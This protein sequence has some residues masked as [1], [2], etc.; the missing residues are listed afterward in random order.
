[1]LSD[2]FTPDPAIAAWLTA[3]AKRKL[4]TG[5]GYSVD[6]TPILPGRYVFDQEHLGGERTPKGVEAPE[7]F[8]APGRDRRALFWRPR[9]ALS[10]RVR[11]SVCVVRV[12]AQHAQAVR[13][14]GREPVARLG[15]GR[16]FGRARAGAER[17]D[18]GLRWPFGGAVRRAG[19]LDRERPRLAHARNGSTTR[20][21]LRKLRGRGRD[22]ARARVADRRRA[23]CPS[24]TARPREGLTPSARSA[25]DRLHVLRL[26][27]KVQPGGCTCPPIESRSAPCCGRRCRGSGA[28]S[29][30]RASLRAGSASRSRGRSRRARRCV[31]RSTA[32][33][34]RRRSSRRRSAWAW[35]R[36]ASGPQRRASCSAR[37]SGWSR[38]AT[39]AFGGSRTASTPRRTRRTSRRPWSSF[40]S[41]LTPEGTALTIVESGFDRVPAHRRARAFRMNEGGWAAQA[42]NLR[43]HV[44]A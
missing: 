36:R 24:S 20:P 38:S 37:S 40:S 27:A 9:A 44:E 30:T 21:R 14:V 22:R 16:R 8:V 26:R 4:M 29:R 33:S 2:V 3:T 34:T 23:R 18:L 31:A 1:M 15:R 5:C 11:H 19:P 10:R 41:S 7:V 6:Y 32:R 17:R 43:K 12:D 35:P 39:S 28:R 13:K 25:T 42:E